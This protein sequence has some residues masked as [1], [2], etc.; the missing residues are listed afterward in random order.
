MIKE[1]F[2][3]GKMLF[4]SRPSDI[5]GKDLELV[6]MDNFP[7]K[8]YRFMCWCGK[9]IL[10]KDRVD[11]INRF[12]QTE[13]GKISIR[14][15][16]GHA[17]QAISEHGDNWTRY[18][19]SYFWHWIKH[20]PWIAPSSACYFFNRYEVECYAKEA[21]KDYW[22]NYSRNNLRTI[23]TLKKPRK[24]WKELGSTSAAWKTYVK[25]L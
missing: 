5:F 8:G 14:H 3:L 18:Y 25:S 9:I 11:I 7:F 1:I 16:K 22:E 23:F 10:R 20:C 4:L 2:Q 15:E 21:D 13:A 6:V 19:F 24:K 17:L 12:L